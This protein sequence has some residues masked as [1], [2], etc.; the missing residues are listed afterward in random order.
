MAGVRERRSVS[1]LPPAM[2]EH[3]PFVILGVYFVDLLVLFAVG[4]VPLAYNL[5][6]VACGGGRTP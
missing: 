4:K 1:L 3:W 6:N 5:R 2:V